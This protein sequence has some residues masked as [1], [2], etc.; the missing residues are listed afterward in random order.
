VGSVIDRADRCNRVRPEFG[1]PLEEVTEIPDVPRG[2]SRQKALK[3]STL[4]IALGTK[5]RDGKRAKRHS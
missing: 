4:R 1:I 5:T 2:A 3:A